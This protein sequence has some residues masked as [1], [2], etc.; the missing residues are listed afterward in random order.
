MSALPRLH[1][2]EEIAEA[3]GVSEWWVKEQARQRRVPFVKV[4]GAYRFTSAH[5]DEI[6]ASHEQRPEHQPTST[7]RRSQRAAM[8]PSV[9]QLRPRRPRRGRAGSDAQPA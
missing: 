4:G 6:V 2:A 7:A 3:L 9:T 1:T 8:D 5:L